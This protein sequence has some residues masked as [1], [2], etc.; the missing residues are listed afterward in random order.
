MK[1]YA[2]QMELG[3]YFLHE[4]P[5]TAT[6]WQLPSVRALLARKGVGRVTGDQ[7]QFGQEIDDR[8]PIKKPTGFM[9][10]SPEVLTLSQTL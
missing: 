3:G 8:E 7:C 5:D 10:N 4:H 9:S 2:R 1:L 6:S